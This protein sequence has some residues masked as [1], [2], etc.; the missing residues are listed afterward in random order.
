MLIDTFTLERTQ[1]LWENT[2][3]YNLTESGL[4]P[5]TIRELLG[6]DEIEALLDLP[7]GYGHTEGEPD[8]RTAIAALHPGASPEQVLVTTGSSEANL[9]TL[10]SLLEAGDEIVFVTPNFMQIHGLARA[11]GANVRQVPLR[12][13]QGRWRLDLDEVV[14]AIGPRTRLISLCNPNNPTG[15]VLSAEE[16]L[17]L[18]EIASRH[19]V[20]LHAD[21]IYRG[22]ELAGDETATLFGASPDVVVTGGMAKAMALAGLRLGWLVAPEKL[23]G[24]AM[25]RQDY[26]TIGSNVLGQR[27]ALHAL[28]PARRASIIARNRVLLRRNLD[29]L[30]SW[31]KARASIFAWVPPEAGAMAF[32]RYDLPISSDDFSRELRETQSVFVVAGSWFGMESHLRLGIGVDP[33][34]FA[35]ALECIDRFLQQRFGIAAPTR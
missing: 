23:V 27:L 33:E 1:S 31:I 12:L 11:L 6:K 21:E 8:L 18:A 28:Q 2:V 30:A 24:E 13:G 16:R 29:K 34:H 15:A 4:H 25:R 3:A 9:V 5:F 19:G 10:L 32:L 22:A 17:G 7:L 14:A 35:A 20:T 26:T